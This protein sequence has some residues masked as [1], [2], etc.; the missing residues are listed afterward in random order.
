[1]WIIYLD[2]V[3]IKLDVLH[4]HLGTLHYSGIRH[5]VQK[6]VLFPIFECH[7]ESKHQYFF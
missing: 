5:T 7:H 3:Y 6:Y 2:V 1:M 4:E